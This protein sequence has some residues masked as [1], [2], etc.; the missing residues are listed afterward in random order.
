MEP[1]ELFEQL[2]IA[3]S[4]VFNVASNVDDD[5]F[6]HKEEAEKWSIAEEI[7]HLSL[8][9]LPINNLLIQTSPTTERWGHSNRKSRSMALFL[10]DYEKKV[11]GPVWKAFP[12]FVPKTENENLNYPRLHY[13]SDQ[14]KIDDFY[15]LTGKQIELV[16]EKF[17]IPSLGNKND[18]IKI[19]KEQS[20]SLLSISKKMDDA[21]MDDIQLP[22]PY[23]GLVTFKEILYFTLNHTEHH[24]NSIKNQSLKKI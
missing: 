20:N 19:F 13:T 10:K 18:I 24:F 14:N 22:L 4:E 23:I 17:Q 21:Q 6:F 3:F 2:E 1:K 12:P 11:S 8:S 16:R 9:I 7:Q 5:L 15:K